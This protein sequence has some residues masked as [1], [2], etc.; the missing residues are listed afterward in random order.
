M[1]NPFEKIGN[2]LKSAANKWKE[3]KESRAVNAYD[4]SRQA[5]RKEVREKKSGSERHE[6][7]IKAR[8]A[9]QVVDLAKCIRGGMTRKDLRAMLRRFRSYGVRYMLKTR[10]GTFVNYQGARCLVTKRG[11]FLPI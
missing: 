9:I 5:D 2:F 7:L 3:R 1:L 4:E 11:K 10:P 6:A 8:A